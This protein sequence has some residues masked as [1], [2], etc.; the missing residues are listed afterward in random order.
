[1]QARHNP[2]LCI[3]SVS[4]HVVYQQR[5]SSTR[6]SPTTSRQKIHLWSLRLGLLL[7]SLSLLR[8]PVR[9][10]VRPPLELVPR[11]PAARHPQSLG[12]Q[13]RQ[14]Q[15]DGAR[16]EAGEEQR[17]ARGAV[18]EY[19]PPQVVSHVHDEHQGSVHVFPVPRLGRQP[20]GDVLAVVRVKRGDKLPRRVLCEIPLRKRHERPGRPVLP[21]VREHLPL[22][23]HRDVRV[24]LDLEVLEQL[25]R[26]G[27]RL[28]DGRDDELVGARVDAAGQTVRG[29]VEVTGHLPALRA[30]RRVKLDEVR[31]DVGSAVDAAGELVAGHLRRARRRRG[32]G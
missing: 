16:D 18:I 19:R 25:A 14:R 32:R 12:D 4:L 22:V 15:R 1:M 5:Q 13:V 8:L 20:D 31:H 28:G 9:L 2:G 7:R 27:G 21:R 30:P 3:D 6:D 29:R 23:E 26:A 17:D 10:P 24:R 11:L